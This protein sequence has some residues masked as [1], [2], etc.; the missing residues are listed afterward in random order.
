MDVQHAAQDAGF[1]K[2]QDQTA[3]DRMV[4]PAAPQE[5]HDQSAYICTAVFVLKVII[6]S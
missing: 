6:I 2:L 3:A 1:N 4:L 5:V